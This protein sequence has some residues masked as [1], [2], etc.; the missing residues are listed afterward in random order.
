MH[1]MEI[2]IWLEASALHC[3]AQRQQHFDLLRE[4]ILQRRLRKSELNFFKL[5]LKILCKSTI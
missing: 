5:P 4:K 2:G 3:A 1:Q